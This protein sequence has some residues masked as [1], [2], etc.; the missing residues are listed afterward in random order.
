MDTYGV[1]DRSSLPVSRESAS[2]IETAKGPTAAIDDDIVDDYHEIED[3]APSTSETL[4]KK[5]C[6]VKRNLHKRTFSPSEH[7][8]S[9]VGLATS[10]NNTKFKR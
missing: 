3:F 7:A 8:D 4:E 6:E 10:K 1:D 5:T 9:G 2:S